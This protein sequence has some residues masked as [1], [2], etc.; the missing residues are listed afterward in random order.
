MP[1]NEFGPSDWKI[2][3]LIGAIRRELTHTSLTHMH[4]VHEGLEFI[5]TQFSQVGYPKWLISQ[6]INHTMTKIL[7]PHTL[8]QPKTNTTNTPEKKVRWLPLFIPWGG[9]KAHESIKFLRRSIPNDFAKI[10]IAYSVSKI[11]SLLPSFSTNNQSPENKILLSNNLVY[12]Y[13][14]A[15]EKVYIGETQ[16]RLSIRITE[17]QNRTESAIH[18]HILVCSSSDVVERDKFSIVAKRLRHR[19]ARKRFESIY[20][21]YYDKRAHSTMNGN[22][23]SRELACF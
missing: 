9:E 4:L 10:S 15:C 6:K 22:K 23:S 14:C 7:Y 20:I 2:G 5:Q 17:H 12:K 19:D 21:R 16:R 1:W 8:P 18:D 13:T 11:R 3:T